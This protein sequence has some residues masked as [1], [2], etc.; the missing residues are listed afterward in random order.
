M[1]E[2]AVATGEA[3][4]ACLPGL[5]ARL[6]HHRSRLPGSR[7]LAPYRRWR[8]RHLARAVDEARLHVEEG[9]LAR[10]GGLDG[11]R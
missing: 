7:L 5:L 10:L 3:A 8:V 1:R 6:H 4:G 9:R 11:R 2:I